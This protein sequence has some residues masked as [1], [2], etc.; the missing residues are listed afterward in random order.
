[1]N[2][3]EESGQRFGLP[4]PQE[5]CVASTFDLRAAEDDLEAVKATLLLPLEQ[6]STHDLL[7]PEFIQDHIVLCDG[8]SRN[9]AQVVTLSGLRGILDGYV[10]FTMK[11]PSCLHHS[12]ANIDLSIIASPLLE[13]LPGSP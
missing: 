10:V 7:T 13:E 11:Y 8:P 3:L 1:M 5:R 4:S 12:Q 9:K 6:S 2:S